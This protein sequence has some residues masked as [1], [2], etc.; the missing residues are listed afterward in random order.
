MPKRWLLLM[1]KP[2]L[3][4]CRAGTKTQTRRTN[5]RLA[6]IRKRDEIFFRS[7]YKTTYATAS[8]PYLAT[9]DATTEKAQDITDADCIAEGVNTEGYVL[10]QEI[11]AFGGDEYGKQLLESMLRWR[12]RNLWDSINKKPGTRW[13]DNPVVVKIE[14]LLADDGGA[15]RD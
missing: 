12:F 6:G 4:K 7:D 15:S 9:A 14:F 8:G 13:Q 2:N 5:P 11:T 10:L 3:D 1:T